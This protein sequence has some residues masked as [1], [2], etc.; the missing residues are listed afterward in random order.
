MAVLL[1]ALAWFALGRDERRSD[2]PLGLFGSIPIMWGEGD[3]L[4]APP[5]WARAELELRGRLVPLDS[6]AGERPGAP[7]LDGIARLVM[8]Q[9]R[10]LSPAENVALDAWVR[11]G[12]LLLLVVDPAYTGH[13]AYALGDPRRPQAIAMLSPILAHWGLRLEYDPDQAAGEREASALG[14]ALIV[15]QAGQFS[16]IGAPPCKLWDQALVA[17][18]AVGKGRVVALA[19]ASVLDPEDPDGTR[20]RSLASLLDAAFIAR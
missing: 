4:N 1:L 20:A 6:L 7:P 15:E 17:T 5:H 13:S 8:A 11:G 2:V 12:G 3:G 18:C 9:P 14:A 10:A 16:L 19:D